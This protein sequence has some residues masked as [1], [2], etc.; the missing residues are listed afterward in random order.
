MMNI[1][2]RV[3][4]GR[5]GVEPLLVDMSAVTT[6]KYAFSRVIEALGGDPAVVKGFLAPLEHDCWPP[7]V[8]AA[9]GNDEIVAD[10]DGKLVAP[11][12]LIEP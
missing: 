9:L 1:T 5:L 10:W 12:Q 3:I 8:D 7:N 4:Q 11:M 2:L 6:G